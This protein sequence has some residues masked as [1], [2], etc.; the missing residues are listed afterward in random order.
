MKMSDLRGKIEV[1]KPAHEHDYTESGID[2]CY[3][4]IDPAKSSSVKR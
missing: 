4:K 1:L 2:I 3:P